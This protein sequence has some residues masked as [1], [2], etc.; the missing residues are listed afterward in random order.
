MDQSELT[1]STE[2]NP[3]REAL[4]RFAGLEWRFVRGE[5]VW[6]FDDA[7]RRFLDAYAQYGVLALGHNAPAVSSAIRRALESNVPAMVQPYAAVH[8]EALAR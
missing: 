8:A 6:L 2:I 7:G 5:G 1:V 3:E 4:M